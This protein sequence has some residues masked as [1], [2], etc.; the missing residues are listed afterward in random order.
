[1]V[2]YFRDISLSKGF[3]RK[4][5]RGGATEKTRPKIAP[6]SLSL[7]YQYTMYVNSGDTAPSAPRFRCPCPWDAI[8]GLRIYLP[9][10][11][12][13]KT[14]SDVFVSSRQAATYYYM[15]NHRLLSSQSKQ[16]E[17][18]SKTPVWLQK[19]RSSKKATFALIMQTGY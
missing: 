3:D 8:Y 9:N 10:F 7:L 5:F 15:S 18:F 17:K 19:S 12:G 6:L 14:A 2:H 1:V 13:Q 11:P 16:S 4:I